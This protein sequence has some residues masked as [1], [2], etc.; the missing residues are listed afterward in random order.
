MRMSASEF[1][2][3]PRRDQDRLL[4]EEEERERDR[5]F[6]AWD[7]LQNA[8]ERAK[9][10]DKDGKVY[11]SAEVMTVELLAALLDRDTS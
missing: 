8:I 5:E 10:K 4:D 3:L 11:T 1:F 6:N 7:A 9:R 2:A